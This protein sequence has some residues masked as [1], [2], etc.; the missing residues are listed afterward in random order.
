MKLPAAWQVRD[1]VL[2][3]AALACLYFL[4]Y[5]LVW[6]VITPLQEGLL[7][8][9]TRF[10]SLL[11]LPH[12]IRVLATALVGGKAVPGLVLG[13]LAGNYLLWGIHDPV[14]LL[15]ASLIAG[16]VTWAVFEGL[17][18]LRI[19]AFYLRVT[20]EPPPFH[21]L[22]L[23]GILASAANAFLLTSLLEPDLGAGSVMAILAAYMTGD[24]T[25]LLAVL[26]GAHYIM[27]LVSRACE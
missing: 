26:L 15:L 18:V 8:E 10:A 17:F 16:T 24:I 13:E 23:A 14:T 19:N 2:T 20:D 6:A 27:P 25:G 21:T 12:G 4:A 11:F 9:I 3:T 22:M 1:V 5:G 7:P